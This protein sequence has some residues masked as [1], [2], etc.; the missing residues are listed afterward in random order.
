MSKIEPKLI[1]LF[2]REKK[3]K[4]LFGLLQLKIFR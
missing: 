3:D 1:Y 4:Q 2:L